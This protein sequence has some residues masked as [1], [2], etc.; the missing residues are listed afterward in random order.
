[1]KSRCGRCGC[2]TYDEL[3]PELAPYRRCSCYGTVSDADAARMKRIPHWVEHVI[4]AMGLLFVA[5]VAAYVLL[6]V[7]HFI[8]G[9]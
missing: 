6:G 1:M 9:L 2:R 5:G 7:V 3:C 8:R 4:A